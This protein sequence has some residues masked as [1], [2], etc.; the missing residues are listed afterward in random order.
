[1]GTSSEQEA[2]KAAQ[3][4]L[5]QSIEAE[6]TKTWRM[7]GTRKGRALYLLR[8]DRGRLLHPNHERPSSWEKKENPSKKGTEEKAPDVGE[9]D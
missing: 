7:K 6:R 3:N 5:L 1:V 2:F 9:E 4:Y 8:S